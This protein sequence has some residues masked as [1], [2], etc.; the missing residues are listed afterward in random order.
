MSQLYEEILDG[1][2]DL[3]DRDLIQQCW[4]FINNTKKGHPEAEQGKC[5]DLV[6]ARSIAGQVRLQ[7]PYKQKVRR[8]TKKPYRGLAGY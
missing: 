1:S 2:T 7:R 8:Q 6:M 4:T 5:D 3:L